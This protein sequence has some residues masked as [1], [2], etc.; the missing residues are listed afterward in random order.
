MT[1]EV[2][3]VG[4]MVR[5]LLYI[6]GYAISLCLAAMAAQYSSP[7]FDFLSDYSVVLTKVSWLFSYRRSLY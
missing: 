1:S 5:C 4:M 2:F 6:V 7:E 3:S